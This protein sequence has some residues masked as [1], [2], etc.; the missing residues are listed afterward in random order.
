MSRG[1]RSHV[2]R[3]LVQVADPEQILRDRRRSM[4]TPNENE[5]NPRQPH[6]NEEENEPEEVNIP[7]LFMPDLDNI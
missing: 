7:N 6:K 2:D 5:E 4:A 3:S 1:T